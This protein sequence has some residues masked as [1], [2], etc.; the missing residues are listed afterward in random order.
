MWQDSLVEWLN[1]QL[2]NKNDF[3]KVYDIT[4]SETI[5]EVVP[6]ISTLPQK[7]YSDDIT[8]SCQQEGYPI[9]TSENI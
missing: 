3:Q 9:S 6:N 8:D 4:Y 5:L 1:K 2:K 7:I